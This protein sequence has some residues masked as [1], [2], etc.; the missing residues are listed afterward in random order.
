MYLVSL[1]NRDRTRE[2]VSFV[3]IGGLIRPVPIAYRRKPRAG[4]LQTASKWGDFDLLVLK[5][6]GILHG[7]ILQ[8][9]N[10]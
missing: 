5:I 9:E 8:S 4:L 10:A 3:V 1:M 2:K 6:L 7:E